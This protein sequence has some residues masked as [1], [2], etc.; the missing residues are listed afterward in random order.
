MK[1]I[2]S[3]ELTP[4]PVHSTPVLIDD[5]ENP[6]RTSLGTLRVDATDEGPDHSL[7]LFQPVL[8]EG[9][10]HTLLLEAK[11][12]AKRR[13]YVRLDLPLTPGGVDLADVSMYR[14]ISFIARGHCECRIVMA[15]YNIRNHAFF[16]APF[17][18]SGD[19]TTV[20]LPFSSLHS[21]SVKEKWDARSMRL[22]DFEVSGPAGSKA[23]IELD[24]V[25][26][27]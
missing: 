18:V 20:M 14:G 22:A 23:W 11:L 4:L 27:Y 24:K 13:P 2:G 9:S 3:R 19:W 1:A 17:N 25:E 26:F 15:S 5:F 16:A 21:A 6:D 12:A 7:L 8:R 10:H